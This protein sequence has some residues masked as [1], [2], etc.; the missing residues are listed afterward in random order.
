MECNCSLRQQAVGD[1]CIVCNTEYYIDALPTPEELC[2]ELEF[3]FTEDQAFNISSDVY[4][5]LLTLVK[6]LNDK[7][8]HLTKRE[9]MASLKTQAS[10]QGNNE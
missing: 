9:E 6:V 8:N 3:M 5:P 1:G 7:V 10:Q 2:S 4:Q